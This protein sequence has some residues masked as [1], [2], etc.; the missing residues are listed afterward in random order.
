MV[1]VMTTWGI[2]ADDAIGGYRLLNKRTEVL[3]FVGNYVELPCDTVCVLPC[4]LWGDHGCDCDGEFTEARWSMNDSFLS[5][6]QVGSFVVID[7]NLSNPVN[8]RGRFE[9]RDNKMVFP[10]S[11]DGEKIT[12]QIIGYKCDEEGFP[13]ILQNHVKACA[14]YIQMKLAEQTRF[15]TKEYRISE[16]GMAAIERKWH[17]LCR[18]ARATDGEPTGP[19]LDNAINIINNPYSGIRN[20]YWLYDKSPIYGLI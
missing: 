16:A 4:F 10:C 1:P 17:R 2:E 13:M 14:Q 12:V 11:Y 9:V 7:N 8:L 3:T 6:S 20:G 15:K 18:D 5:I 19:E